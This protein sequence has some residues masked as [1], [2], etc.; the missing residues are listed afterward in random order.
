MEPILT[1]SPQ[2]AAELQ[3]QIKDDCIRAKRAAA[4]PARD[5]AGKYRK[6]IAELNER[7]VQNGNELLRMALFANVIAPLRDPAF[8]ARWRDGWLRSDAVQRRAQSAG[9]LLRRGDYA[10]F[11]ALLRELRKEELEIVSAF[12]GREDGAAE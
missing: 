7:L 2:R 12:G 11:A 10:A 3:A 5:R 9:D 8:L 1:E 4:L 6:A